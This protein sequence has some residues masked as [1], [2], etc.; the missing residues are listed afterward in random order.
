MDKTPSKLAQFVGV[1]VTSNRLQLADIEDQTVIITRCKLTKGDFGNYIDFT[2]TLE[3]GA[4]VE[5][6][7]YNRDVLQSLTMASAAD[8][9]PVTATFVNENGKWSIK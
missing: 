2:A 4:I 5:V 3:S 7:T 1:K 9:L 8:A 6:R